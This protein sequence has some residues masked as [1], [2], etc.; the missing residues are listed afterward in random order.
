[1]PSDASGR[2]GDYYLRGATGEVYRKAAGTWGASIANLTGPTGATGAQGPTGAGSTVNVAKDG[3]AVTAAPRATLNFSGDV[4]VV[5]NPGAGRAD[6]TV[7]AR[8][9]DFLL[10]AQ[11]IY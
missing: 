8:P 1:V 3:V 2:D 4:T 11:G 10:M 9:P 7:T 6:I 5:D